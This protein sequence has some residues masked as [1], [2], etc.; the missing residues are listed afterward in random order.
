MALGVARRI[1]GLILNS[2]VASIRHW[3]AD[4][5]EDDGGTASLMATARPNA[6][7]TPDPVL[8]QQWKS[9][10]DTLFICFIFVFGAMVFTNDANQLVPP[11]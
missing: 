3:E 10:L 11:R 9:L 8:D 6:T 2:A 7:F 5:P 1:H 4:V